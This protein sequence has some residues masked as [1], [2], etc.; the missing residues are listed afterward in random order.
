M[1]QATPSNS[2]GVRSDP[3]KTKVFLIGGGV[4]SLAAAVFLIRDGDI[5]GC[6]ITILE[7]LDTIGGSLDGSGSAEAGYV[8]RGGRML[9]SKYLCTFDLFSSIPTLDETG[10]VTQETFAWNETMKTSSKSRLVRD[11]KRQTAPK[12]GLSEAHILTIERLALEPEGMLGATMISDQFDA[13]FFK[14][15][16]WFMWCTTFAFQPWHSAVEFKRYLVRFAHM[17]DGFDRLSGIMRTVYNQYDSMV[18]PLQKWLQ[19]R[20]V[21]VE[22]NTRVTDLQMRGGEGELRVSGIVYD[23]AGEAGEIAVGDQGLVLLTLGSMTEASSLGAMDKAPKLLAKTDGGAWTLWEKLAAGRPEFGHPEVF[24][25]HI[26]ESKWISFTTTMHDPTFLRIVNELT[27]NVPGEG[28][29]ITFPDSAWL[30]SIVIPHQPHFIGQPDGVSVLWGYGLSVDQPGDFVKKPMSACTGAEIMTE[31]MGH[32]RITAEAAKI[33]CTSICI[34]CMM[35]FITSQF[36]PREKG[37]RPQITP[38]GSQNFAFI[39]QFCEMPDDVVFTVEYSIRSAQTAV[40]ALLG[41]K[42]EPPAVYQGKFDPKVLYRAFRALHD[43]PT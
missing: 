33:L 15:D 5:P 20:E 8:L 4:A 9:E 24:A 25:N 13:A 18:R 10:T 23:R 30:A 36:L 7:E 35:P 42:L 2:Q 3:A 28:G 22:L 17:V 12:F 31:V 39:G 34:P 1:A 16:F 43:A 37:D 27:G 41:L 29:L 14:T 26:N 6:N 38:K 19:A 32:L 40:Y 11:G 21:K